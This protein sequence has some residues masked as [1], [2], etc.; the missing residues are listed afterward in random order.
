M[1][2][3]PKAAFAAQVL[4]LA[5]EAMAIRARSHT[6]REYFD[7]IDRLHTAT[8]ISPVLLS[9]WIISGEVPNNA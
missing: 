3:D 5:L 7:A 9:N 4:R 8:G 2:L 1:N 6:M